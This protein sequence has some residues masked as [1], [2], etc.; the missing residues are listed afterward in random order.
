MRAFCENR[1]AIKGP[2]RGSHV[3]CIE[4]PI[5]KI[6]GPVCLFRSI[7]PQRLPSTLGGPSASRSQC[8]SWPCALGRCS[9]KP[10]ADQVRERCEREAV[11]Y[12]HRLGA[13]GRPTFDEG[14][15]TVLVV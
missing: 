15:R 5:P 2:D 10:G 1:N 6:L 9:H 4:P 12:H 3:L 13:A 14:E 7:W 11:R 8:A